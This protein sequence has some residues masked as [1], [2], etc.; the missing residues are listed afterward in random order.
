MGGQGL[1][2]FPKFGGIAGENSGTISG[3]SS[4]LNMNLSMPAMKSWA[5]GIVGI[6]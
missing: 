3:C 6:E 1:Q 5:G 4:R 2:E